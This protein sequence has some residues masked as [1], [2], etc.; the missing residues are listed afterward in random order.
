MSNLTPT[1]TAQQSRKT[2]CNTRRGSVSELLVRRYLRRLK[3]GEIELRHQDGRRYSLGS[4]AEDG[5]RAR[6]TVRDSKFYR[7]LV[8]GGE[9]GLAE[10]RIAGHWSSHDMTSLLRIFCRNLPAAGRMETTISRMKRLAASCRHWLSGNTRRGSRRNIAAHYDLGNDFFSLFLDS[11]LMYS[12]ALFDRDHTTLEEASRNRLDRICQRLDLQPGDHIVEV[13]TGWGGFAL[14]AAQ[15][16]GCRVTT[17]TI[18]RRQYELVG[19]RVGEAGLEDRIT[20]LQQDYRNLRGTYDK[21][22]SIE[23][24]EAVGHG[25]L[26]QYFATCRNLLRPGG[27]MLIQAITMP[28]QRYDRY[29]RSIDFIRRYIFP[30]GHLPSV[31]AMQQAVARR[32]DLFLTSVDQF[33]ESYARTLREWRRRFLERLD[34]VRQLGFDE[35]FVRMWEYY[36]C[37]CEAAF[38]EKTVGVGHFVW[39]RPGISGKSSEQSR[40]VAH[41][42]G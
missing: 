10:S 19:S 9:L 32:T 27:R 31:T 24:I 37:Y 39:E 16:Y 15:H 18:S 36:L 7:D 26:P 42:V 40:E 6:L 14:H 5:L 28:D 38:L 1:F 21:L 29:R 22:V 3:E 30:G 4:P 8:R 17:T 2:K 20:L 35:R 25:F 41:G 13:G 11:S 12:S 23:M 34:D 33:P